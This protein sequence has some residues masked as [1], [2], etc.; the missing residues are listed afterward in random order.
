MQEQTQKRI[1]IFVIAIACLVFI[2]GIF[3]VNGNRITYLEYRYANET[4]SGW[5]DVSTNNETI[6]QEFV[7]PYNVIHGVSF[8]VGTYERDNNSIYVIRITDK[9]GQ[10]LYA[11]EYGASLIDDTFYPFEFDKNIKLE[12][13]EKYDLQIVAKEVTDATCIA[14]GYSDVEE[15]DPSM[16][17]N[18]VE[19]TGKAL[20]LRIYGGDYDVWWFGFAVVLSV[21]LLIVSGRAIYLIYNN[22]KMKDDSLL[23][24]LLV[25]GVTF[26]LI[27]TFSVTSPFTDENDNIRGGMIIARG[28][29]LYRDYVTQHTPVAY[30]LCALFALLGAG[31]VA[32]FRLSYY[33]FISIIWALVFSRHKKYYGAKKMIFLVMLEMMI[34]F[35]MVLP[36]GCQIL[37]EGIQGICM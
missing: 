20:N 6:T 7:A 34:V 24:T 21:Y 2:A 11:K 1:K 4:C 29:V 3:A 15:N 8:R 26:L 33:L 13:G 30:Y 18:G 28:G 19:Q 5:L 9:Q 14:L 37:S 35:S 22:K 16:L 36:Q 25:G 23:T 31:S 12:K 32:Q 17:I 27:A 10:V